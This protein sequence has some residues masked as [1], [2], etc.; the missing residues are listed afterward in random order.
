MMKRSEIDTSKVEHGVDTAWLVNH[1]RQLPAELRGAALAGRG[2][3][4]E[5]RRHTL[6]ELAP[7]D[8]RLGTT[9]AA[10]EKAFAEVVNRV[11]DS[12]YQVLAL[13]TCTGIDSYNKDDRM[14]ALNLRHLVNNPSRYHV[15]MDEL[16]I[17]RWANC[18]S[19]C[20]LTVGTRLH[21]AIISMNFRHASHC[22]Q[23]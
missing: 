22:H 20:D 9:Q 10:Y 19:A 4:T 15:V 14:V 6:R 8:K 11:L 12:G 16:T 1:Q 2:G 7:F 13:S 3:E 17:W 5:N 18:S 23:L 21:S